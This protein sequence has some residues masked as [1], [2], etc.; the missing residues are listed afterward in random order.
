MLG[1]ILAGGKSRRFGRPKA[2]ARVGGATFLERVYHALEG[3][4]DTV[5]LSASPSTPGEAVELARRMGATIVWDDPGLP[6]MGP[7]RGVASA[8]LELRP[9]A[10]LIVGVDYPFITSG[11]LKSIITHAR[12]LRAHSLTPY[13]YEGYPLVTLGYADHRALELLVQAC[14]V[15]PKVRLT[16]LY[17]Q[18]GALVAGWSLYTPNPRILVNVNRPEDLEAEPRPPRACDIRRSAGEYYEAALEALGAGDRVA[19]L[20]ALRAEAVELERQGLLLLAR[21]AMEDYSSIKESYLN[22]PRL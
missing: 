2:L 10:V 7:P 18:R 17:R 1:I 4:V 21:H 15:K 22:S 11:A 16:D 12:C 14:R 5:A 20:E 8:Y 9:E 6:C 3:V 19:A 13:L